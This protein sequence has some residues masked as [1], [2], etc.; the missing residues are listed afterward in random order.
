LIIKYIW[1]KLHQ[2]FYGLLVWNNISNSTLLRVDHQKYRSLNFFW[3]ARF[4]VEKRL[5]EQASIIPFKNQW[6]YNIYNNR[7]SVLFPIYL[8]I[9]IFWRK[10][11]FTSKDFSKETEKKESKPK[12]TNTI[13]ISLE[14]KKDITQK[15]TGKLSIEQTKIVQ[16]ILNTYN[17]SLK[18]F[19]NLHKITL[20]KNTLFIAYVEKFRKNIYIIANSNKKQILNKNKFDNISSTL[21]LS[22][23]KFDKKKY[24][25]FMIMFS[26]NSIIT[27]SIYMTLMYIYEGCSIIPKFNNKSKIYI[28]PIFLSSNH[29][30]RPKKSS[31]TALSDIQSWKFCNWFVKIDIKKIFDKITEKRLLS[32]IREKIDD[33]YLLSLIQ[34]IV[35]AK[36]LV[37]KT[38]CNNNEKKKIKISEEN[39]L[40][41][42]L[43]NIY[44]HKIDEFVK[45]KQ[46]KI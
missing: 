11:F 13:K 2:K 25:P 24:H 34:Q 31:H 40:S 21:K 4:T 16:A 8:N 41:P 5:H 10:S 18:K 32:I 19:K 23:Y 38:N 1:K 28:K 42:L 33:E 37:N 6:W 43:T 9:K 29:G 35:N 14:K 12:T 17:K 44:L 26:W 46:K 27:Y 3:T 30:F 20:K 7:N 45:K 15:K 39:P 22:K 36:I